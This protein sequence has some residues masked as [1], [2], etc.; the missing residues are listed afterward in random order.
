MARTFGDSPFRFDHCYDV[1]VVGFGYAGGVAAIAAADAGA[2]VLLIE[3]QPNPG[4]V[5]VC[6]GGGVRCAR[7]ADDA[8]AYLKATNAGTTPDDV[9]RVFADGMAEVPDHVRALAAEVGATVEEGTARGL[10]GN[11][12]FP[13]WETFY[14][15]TI[16]QMP[17]FDA[18][19][20]YPHV[21]GRA[22]GTG[23]RLFR[24][25]EENIAK[26]RIDVR[27]GTP[28]R[29]LLTDGAGE[30]S[31]ILVDAPTGELRIGA[32]RGV[33]LASGGF[34]NCDE[35]KRQYWETKPVLYATGRGNTGDGIRMA[36]SVGAALWHMWHFH[37]CYAFRHYD[38][39]F[40][41]ALRVK[42]LPDWNPARKNEAHVKMAW[43]VVDGSGRRYMNECPPYAQD[44]GHRPMG[45]FDPETMSYPRIPSYLI[46]DEKGRQL[47]RLGDVRTNDPDFWYEWSDDNLKEIQNG[48]LQQ[49][50]TVGELARVVGVEETAMQATL[51]RWNA[52]CAQGS[53]EEFGRPGGTMMSIDTPPYIVSKVWP[54]VSNTQG[55]PVHDARQRV[56]DVYGRPIPR[57]LSAGELGSSFGHLYLSGGNIAE[58]FITGR[59][60]GSEVA[61]LESREMNAAASVV[62]LGVS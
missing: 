40:P 1:I 5:S 48:I 18:A 53:D 27:L 3:K 20:M 57:L 32:R 24:V 34:E 17:N 47:Y 23:I 61:S 36:Q 29:R 39:E 6:S 46:A 35:L 12:P 9:L 44:T 31:G 13:G 59:I 41:F 55:G 49:V 2:S 14:A 60:A 7:D 10:G 19:R 16:S 4:G 30:V 22:A 45:A 42:R 26:R 21:R 25:L 51:D 43:I 56:I 52:H 11:Y 54:T 62:S 58:C 28:A 37:G 50:E 33:V 38:P 15:V 8:F